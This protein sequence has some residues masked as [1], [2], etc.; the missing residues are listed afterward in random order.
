[1]ITISLQ[2]QRKKYSY[3]DGSV[4]VDIIGS[5]VNW[6]E[7][8]YYEEPNLIVEYMWEDDGKKHTAKQ[9]FKP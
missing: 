9:I 7:R 2:G 5:M 4:L 1:M 8:I 6:K 3:V